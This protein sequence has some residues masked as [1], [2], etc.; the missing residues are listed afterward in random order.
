MLVVIDTN[1]M[2]SALARQTPIAP[3]F[4]ALANGEI[5]L[6]LTA[7]IVVG[8]GGIGGGG[9]GRAF[10]ARLLHWLSLVAT[11]W[12]TIV[13]VHPSYQFRLISSDPDDNKFADCA[14]T[15]NADFLITN[16]TDYAPLVD[17]GYKPQLI[18]PEVF[19]ARYLKP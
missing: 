15:A 2:I 5:Q 4:R 3:L 1:V 13:L 16:D 9:G 17:S 6:A 18:K 8:G 19:I 10:S 11:A 12:K 7:A 14:I